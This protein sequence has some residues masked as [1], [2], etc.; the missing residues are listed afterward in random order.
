[1]GEGWSD[2]VGL[3]LT[4]N[5]TDT[6]ATARGVGTYVSFQPGGGPGIRPTPYSTDMTVDPATYDTIKDA[7]NISVP[8]G[9][10]YVWNSMLREVYW[11][12][13]DRYGYNP[14]IYGAWNTG[15][16]PRDPARDLGDEA[17][18]VQPG[19]RRR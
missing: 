3:V 16:K 9:I 7:A 2:F 11:N 12:L 18:A 10:G 8:H 4:M 15:G 19:L 6:R 17:P 1:M 13:V 14:N 5:E